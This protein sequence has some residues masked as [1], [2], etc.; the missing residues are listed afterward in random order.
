MIEQPERKCQ[1]CG[2]LESEHCV[3]EASGSM[4]V[5]CTCPLGEWDGA[6]GPICKAYVGVPPQNCREC[7]HDLE[8]HKP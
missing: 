7:E 3:F 8:C 6:P 2:V 4:L 1:H 5:G